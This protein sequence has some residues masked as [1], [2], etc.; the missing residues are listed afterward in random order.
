MTIYT[1]EVVKQRAS[2]RLP[3]PN[4][5][6]KVSRQTTLE[7]TINP[8]NLNP[9]RSMKSRA[10]INRELIAEASTWKTIPELCRGC[11]E[12]KEG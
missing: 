8:Y 1:F 7:Q 5:G 6:K 9:D 3:C 11:S 12:A 2:K 4:C 10:D